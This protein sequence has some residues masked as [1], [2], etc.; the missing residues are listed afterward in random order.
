MPWS[1]EAHRPSGATTGRELVVVTT[2]AKN[3]RI[4]HIDQRLDRVQILRNRRHVAVGQGLV[5]V[6]AEAARRLRLHCVLW[7]IE[8]V[9]R[10]NGAVVPD[11]RRQQITDSGIEPDSEIV[12]RGGV[13]V[14]PNAVFTLIAMQRRERNERRGTEQLHLRVDGRARRYSPGCERRDPIPVGVEIVDHVCIAIAG[15]CEQDPASVALRLTAYERTPA[16]VVAVVRVDDERPGEIH[17]KDRVLVRV[18]DREHADPRA[19]WDPL[20]IGKYVHPE[21]VGDECI[22]NASAHVIRQEDG[23]V[24]KGLER[25]HAE[26]IGMTVR[27]PDIP[28]RRDRRELLVRN[29]MGKDPAPEIRGTEQPWIGRQDRDLVV[30]D[31]RRVAHRFESKVICRI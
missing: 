24:P 17:Q 5:P 29:L 16:V 11:E 10:T 28:T 19:E 7:R 9:H 6:I 26:M 15:E 12:K 22:A 30:R 2:H 4:D 31:Q 27:D 21:T 1:A 14:D 8:S 23:L 13:F 20:A 25:R 3:D 18:G